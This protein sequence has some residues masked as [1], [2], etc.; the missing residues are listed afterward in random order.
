[1]N[2]LTSLGI[3]I[4]AKTGPVAK[5]PPNSLLKPLPAIAGEKFMGLA[6]APL[7]LMVAVSGSEMLVIGRAE[8]TGV[9]DTTAYS[10][11]SAVVVER[12]QGIPGCCHLHGALTVQHQ[13]VQGDQSRWHRNVKKPHFAWWDTHGEVLWNPCHYGPRGGSGQWAH[14]DTAFTQSGAQGGRGEVWI[15]SFPHRYQIHRAII[16][17]L[18][19]G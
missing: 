10:G 16:K 18:S 19:I 12:W 5:G 13:N 4:E 15:Q 7:I 8:S 9:I 2:W 1:M 6:T 3:V 14:L 11:R 17:G